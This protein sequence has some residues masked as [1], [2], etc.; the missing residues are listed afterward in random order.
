[1]PPGKRRSPPRTIKIM[2]THSD[3]ARQASTESVN[4]GGAARTGGTP[5]GMS[6]RDVELRSEL[7]RH[8]GRDVFPANREELLGTLRENN[9]SDEVVQSITGLPDDDTRYSNMQDVAR[10]LGLGTETHRT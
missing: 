8:L 1:M 10:G 7:A 6:P 5:P 4:A 2:A 3:D 9:A